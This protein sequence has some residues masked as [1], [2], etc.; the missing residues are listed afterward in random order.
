MQSRGRISIV[1]EDR[2]IALRKQGYDYD[3]IARIVNCKPGSCSVV[4]R[5]WIRRPPENVDPIKR[6]RKRGF[7]SDDQIEYIRNQYK[8]GVTQL[9]LA[10]QFKIDSTAIS[11]ICTHRTYQNPSGDGGYVYNFTNRLRRAA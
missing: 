1:K 11:A 10:K 7:L 6:G 5:R 8:N 2:I 3:T 4:L 9:T